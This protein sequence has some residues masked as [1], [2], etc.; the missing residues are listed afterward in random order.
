VFCY[1]ILKRVA[2]DK[3]QLLGAI[4]ELQRKLGV[5]NM[6]LGTIFTILF[7]HNL[8]MGTIS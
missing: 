6:A 1:S 5:V 7:L 3:H 2:R 8:G 4:H